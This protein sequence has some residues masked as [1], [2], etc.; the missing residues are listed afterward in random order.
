VCGRRSKYIAG[1]RQHV[2]HNT[3]NQHADE[4][5]RTEAC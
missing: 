4:H 3:R 5:F 1:F 2:R